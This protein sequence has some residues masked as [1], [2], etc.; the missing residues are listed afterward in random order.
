VESNWKERGTPAGSGGK[1]VMGEPGS[2]AARAMAHV[3]ALAGKIGGR[4]SGTASVR[5]AAEYAVDQMR[6]FGARDAGIEPFRGVASTYQ[7]YALAFAAALLGTLLAWVLPGRPGLA[8][9]ALL[10]LVGTWGMLAESDFAGNWMRRLLPAATGH[11]AVGML[12]AFGQVQRRAVLC[13]H[14]DTHRTPVFYSSPA[15]QRLFSVLVS[16]AFASMAAGVVIYGLGAA[17]DWRWVRWAG[18]VA[19]SVQLFALALSLH[20]ECTP[21]SPGA[22]DNASGVGVAL[23]LGQ[24]LAR[25]PLAHTEVWLALTDCEE[26]AAQGMVAFLDAHGA[27]L[28]DDAVYVVLDQVGAGCLTWLTVDGLIVKRET[29]PRALDLARRAATALPD[30][31]TWARPGVAYTDAAVATKRGLAALTLSS[32]PVAEGGDEAHWHQ[33]SDTPEVVNPDS[34]ADACAFSWQVLQAVDDDEK[35]YHIDLS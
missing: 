19:G 23:A 5:L 34:L 21:F 18:L 7:P 17:L 11:N 28:G 1:G 35:A 30:V 4:G 13:A 2:C 6:R 8:A 26:T 24:R 32:I 3:H 33:M 15:W 27:A 31:E 14:L 16:G 10:H 9:A 20:A 29:R 22:N 25:E 12:P